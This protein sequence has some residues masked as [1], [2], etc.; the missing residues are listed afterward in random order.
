MTTKHAIRPERPGRIRVRSAVLTLLTVVTLGFT[1][2]GVS[3]AQQGVEAKPRQ[4][5]T[6]DAA[7]VPATAPLTRTSAFPA[8][9]G[10]HCEPTRAGS[11]ERRAGAAEACVSTSPAPA[12]STATE[13]RTLAAAAVAGGCDITSPGTYSYERFGYCVTGV[14]VVYILR[15]S[16]GKELGRGTLEIST[17]ATLPAS[18]TTWSEQV[19]VTMAAAS[20][21][22]TALNAKFRAACT[23]GCTATKTAPWYGGDL[24]LGQSLT[25]TVAY[26]SAPALNSSVDF[27]TSYKLYVTSPGATA[28]DPNASWDNPRKIRCDD[29]VR[30]VTAEP[31]A[32][33]G[34]VIP[35]VTA[36]VP[37]ST[38]GSDQGGAVAAYLWAQQNLVDHW[39][40]DTLLTRAK[41]GVADRT[42]RTCGSAS[43]K[44]F[45]DAT[46]LIPTDTC[47]AFPFAETQEGGTDG[48]R[49]AEVIPNQGNGG[50]II[51]ELGGGSS[52]DPA[53]PCVRAHVALADK[54]FADGQLSEGFKSQRVIDADQFK[55]ALT[56]S[57]DGSHAACLGVSP[58]GARLAGNGWI[59][60]TTEPV[61]HVNKTTN[62]QGAAGVR[63]TTAQACLGKTPGPGSDAGG[64]ITGWQDAQLFAQ[65]N[66][67]DTAGLS[68]CHLIANILGGRISK[69]L[70][71]CWQVGM[72]TGAGSMWD[73]E[74][75]ARDEVAEQSF[76]EDDA[77]LYQVTPTYLDATSTIPVGVT[78]S[79]V[80]ERE[81]G[82]VE[83]LFPDVYIPNTR[84]NTGLFNLGN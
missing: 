33:P 44:P 29:A 75:Q 14:S 79:A 35:T 25:G 55:L 81:D 11:K 62:P 27:T 22:V 40:R 76:G 68:R 20:G 48:A 8:D 70:V 63:A 47:A 12:E 1:T 31:T 23:T 10:E 53:K 57:I 43:S 18:G 21:E 16:N 58:E 45:A 2:P 7:D 9:S 72:N 37:M 19:T 82:S 34:C 41:S 66:Q 56:A 13:Q 60:N 26:S 49:C 73:Y 24:T 54:Q 51:F 59:L 28:V 52:V 74:E 61:A 15:D 39:G 78:M 38:Q 3:Y 69:N 50:W 4:V 83:Q 84:G 77:I 36:V 30:D 65:A 71:P 42:S 32:S 46:D 17:S 67:L 64:D 80:I 5:G 6:I